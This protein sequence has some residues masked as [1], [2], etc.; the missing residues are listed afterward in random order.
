MGFL[1]GVNTKKTDAGFDISVL[2]PEEANELDKN[3]NSMIERYKDNRQAVN[4]LVFESVAA[5]TAG[6]EYEREL[7]NKRGLKRF[8]GNITGSNKVLQDKINHNRSVAQYASQQT[9]QRLAEQNAMSF[10][11]IAAVNNKLNVSMVA[12][13]KEFVQ[14]YDYLTEFFKRTRSDMIQLENRVERLERNVNLLN[15]QNSIE[16]Q[17]FNGVE[18]SELDDAAKI[19]CLARDFYEITKGEWTTSDLLLLKTAMNDIG[20][21]PKSEGC[22]FDFIK[23]LC[24]DQNL[25]EKLLGDKSIVRQPDAEYLTMFSGIKKLELLETRE[26]YVV[27][28]V[29][30]QINGASDE[31]AI[32]ESLTKSYLEQEAQINSES[33]IGYYNLVLELIYS[34][35]QAENEGL[36][37]VNIEDET[38]VPLSVKFEKASELFRTY[39]PVEVLPLLKELSDAGY[40]EAN[41]LLYWLYH[42]GYYENQRDCTNIELAKEYAKKGYEAGDSICTMLYATFCCDPRNKE[43]AM[44]CLP[45]IQELAD[46]GDIYAEYALGIVDIN[47]LCGDRDYLSAVQH[48]IASNKSGFYRAV[49][50]VF[51]RYYNGN[52][53]FEKDWL[54]GNLWAEEVLKYMCPDEVFKVAYMYMCIEDWG[55]TDQDEKNSFYE[56]A[57]DLYQE[58]IELGHSG[59][60]VNLGWMYETGKWVSEDR[61]KAV[62]YY[63]I[64][65]ER[66]ES[67]AQANLARC[68]ENGKGT[69]QKKI[70]CPYCGAEQEY[71]SILCENCFAML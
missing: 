53:P 38:E 22:Y 68:Y 1:S 24:Y 69:Q 59:A 56:R 27:D 2:T 41:A 70:I 20:I 21:S 66:G 3:I 67:V 26:H 17:M 61:E 15:W 7:S 11:L 4:R 33:S 58:L 51:L 19:V 36:L 62:H 71:G 18:Y 46:N 6:D 63:S 64:A 40:G 16:Y 23:R 9:L 13:E 28:T 39:H 44:E 54:H 8:I 65:A 49:G 14:V 12:V 25:E 50:S 52:E 30:K 60:S 45:K 10:D 47:D 34:L 42:D 35:R 5:M 55:C 43:L 31:M 37:G 32:S 57:V 29:A 48:F